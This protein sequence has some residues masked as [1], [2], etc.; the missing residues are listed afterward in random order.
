MGDG[1]LP[2]GDGNLRRNRKLIKVGFYLELIR[3]VFQAVDAQGKLRNRAVMFTSAMPG[4]GVS[5]VVNIVAKE[6]A[7]QTRNR[8]LLVEATALQNLSVADPKQ[9][10][11]RCEETEIDNLLVLSVTDATSQ[12][13]AVAGSRK[14]G[15]WE[16]SPEYR[17]ECLKVL[18]WNFDYV[19]IDCPSPSISL[20]ASTIAPLIDGVVVVVKAGQT[21]RSQIQ[22]CQ[23][24]IASAGG[25]FLGFVLS[26]RQYPVPKLIYRML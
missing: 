17:A 21:R 5:H 25:N 11:T 6:L 7:A 10:S 12:V 16:S 23:Q 24:I 14:A 26:Q 15:D 2:K 1:R 20:D 22:R 9:I 13:G 3:T 4:E 8:V 19:L 18:R